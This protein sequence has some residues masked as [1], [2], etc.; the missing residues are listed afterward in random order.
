MGSKTFLDVDREDLI[1]PTEKTQF[2]NVRCY[3]KSGVKVP[4]DIDGVDD[5]Q[6]GDDEPPAGALGFNLLKME[7]A[8]KP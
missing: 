8:V 4:D 7:I 5:P 6:G 1:H 3:A 2:T